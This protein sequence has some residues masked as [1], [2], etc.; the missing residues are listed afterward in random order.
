MHVW[1]DETIKNTAPFVREFPDAW[2]GIDGDQY[3]SRNKF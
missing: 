1:D 2:I 3:A